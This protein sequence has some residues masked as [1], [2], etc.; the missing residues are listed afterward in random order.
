[1]CTGTVSVPGGGNLLRQLV[2]FLVVIVQYNLFIVPRKSAD[3][4][5]A[6][7]RVPRDFYYLFIYFCLLTAIAF[8][9]YWHNRWSLFLKKKKKERINKTK[10]VS[11]LQHR[12]YWNKKLPVCEAS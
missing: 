4:S 8:A 3:F 5:A 10:S 12:S 1:M 2:F 7:V 11:S 9:S 6:V